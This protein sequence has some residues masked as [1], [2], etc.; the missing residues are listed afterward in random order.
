M[1]IAEAF[2]ITLTQMMELTEKIVK[3]LEIIDAEAAKTAA[4]AADPEGESL[5]ASGD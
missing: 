3:N 5:G 4:P 2:G 1:K